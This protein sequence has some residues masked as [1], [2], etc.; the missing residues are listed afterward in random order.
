[1][2]GLF[3][4]INMQN[5]YLLYPK[6]FIIEFAAIV[7]LVITIP[8]WLPLVLSLLAGGLGI[9]IFVLII[10][11]IISSVAKS[12]NLINQSDFNLITD[13]YYSIDLII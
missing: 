8:V 2:L 10:G 9:M 12:N 1:M 11:L 13:T 7:F 5:N 4:D 6:A 3:K